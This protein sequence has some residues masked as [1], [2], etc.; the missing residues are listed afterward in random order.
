MAR[1]YRFFRQLPVWL[2]TTASLITIGGFAYLVVGV[3]ISNGATSDSRPQVTHLLPVVAEPFAVPA[4]SPIL[5]A[6]QPTATPM[7]TPTPTPIPPLGEQLEWALSIE[8]I[9]A[10]GDGLKAVAIQSVLLS[11]YWTAIRAAAATPDI[12][13]QATNLELVIDCAIEDGQFSMATE[14][15]NMVE[16][17]SS[18]NDLMIKALA[19]RE[20]AIRRE[21]FPSLPGA[22]SPQPRLM[23]CLE[24]GRE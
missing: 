11:D 5:V 9:A 3:I 19:S 22:Q 13:A 10:R 6:P 16:S 21:A 24:T 23:L 2:Q 15:A 20:A 17:L 7:P 4:V 14:A 12:S 1:L 8:G 18:R